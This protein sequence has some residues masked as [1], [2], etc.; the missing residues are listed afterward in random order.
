[1]LLAGRFKAIL[2]GLKQSLLI[3]ETMEAIEEKYDPP[4]SLFYLGTL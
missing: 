3:C 1:M 2:I 4:I